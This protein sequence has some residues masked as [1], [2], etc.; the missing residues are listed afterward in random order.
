MFSTKSKCVLVLLLVPENTYLSLEYLFHVLHI[1]WVDKYK[2]IYILQPLAEYS[3]D[4]SKYCRNLQQFT[5][6]ALQQFLMKIVEL[7]Q[8]RCMTHERVLNRQ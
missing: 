2:Q 5:Q 4:L 1:I 8:V 7:L 3:I 6:D